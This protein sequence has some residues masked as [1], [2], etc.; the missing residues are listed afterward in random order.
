MGALG[1]W[2]RERRRAQLGERWRERQGGRIGP[3]SLSSQLLSLSLVQAL[4]QVVAYRRWA[5]AHGDGRG[6][7]G[8]RSAGTSDG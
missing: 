6:K 7:T 5:V 2:W 1:E 4:G 3:R 8:G